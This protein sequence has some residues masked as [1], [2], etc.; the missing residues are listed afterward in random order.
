MSLVTHL[1]PTGVPVRPHPDLY[2]SGWP[3]GG[4]LGWQGVVQG[5][6]DGVVGTRVGQGT[7]VVQYQYPGS[8]QYRYLGSVQY[9]YL[10]QSR[11]SSLASQY[12]VA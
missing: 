3:A 8:V 1:W 4:Y 9:Q 6:W 7:R 2:S 5:G 12:P 11:P 10:A